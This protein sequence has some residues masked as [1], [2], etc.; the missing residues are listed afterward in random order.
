MD[1]NSRARLAR[2]VRVLFTGTSG[3]GKSSTL[4]Q[5][6]MFS[7]FHCIPEVPR[8]LLQQDQELE[9]DPRFPTIILSTQ[10]AQEEQGILSGKEVVISDRGL[11]DIA[12]F[13]SY[14][15]HTVP[16]ECLHVEDRYDLVF[17]FS[18]W[19]CQPLP[20]PDSD[21]EVRRIQLHYRFLEYLQE[22][23]IPFTE[24]RGTLEERCLQINTVLNAYL[25]R[26]QK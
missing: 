14:Y 21:Y 19:E 22:K 13:A 3:A 20:S 17:L 24:V 12:V 9:K 11:I 26:S 18:P 1:T 7:D 6:A 10:I 5:Y 2:P 16:N 25:D 15:G 4:D 23:N 8:T